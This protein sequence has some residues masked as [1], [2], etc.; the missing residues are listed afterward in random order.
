MIF[1]DELVDLRKKNGM[2]QEELAEKLGIDTSLLDDLE[3][4][5]KECPVELVVQFS[6]IFGVTIDMLVLGKE[7]ET[8]LSAADRSHLKD[9]IT[10]I[11]AE[12][13]KLK[14]RL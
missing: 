1:A 6:N 11:L 9:E 7:H 13:E 5:K 8:S 4:G 10:T 14:G 12:L 3:A 2:S